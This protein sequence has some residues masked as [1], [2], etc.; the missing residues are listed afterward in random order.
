MTGLPCPA[1]LKLLK[2]LTARAWPECSS[3][4]VEFERHGD[5][6]MTEKTCAACDCQLDANPI[7]VKVGGKAVE[8]CC[9]ECAFALNEAGASAVA[10]SED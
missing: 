1:A 6:I 7:R 10:A 8:V 3:A 9:E 2:I 5:E 4:C